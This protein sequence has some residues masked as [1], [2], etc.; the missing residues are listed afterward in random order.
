MSRKIRKSSW[1]PFQRGDISEKQIEKVAQEIS[2]RFDLPIDA[3]TAMARYSL[4]G[5]VWINNKYQV[6]L[7]RYS[8]DGVDSTALHLSIKRIDKEPIR[9]WRDLQRIKNELCGPEVELVELYPKESR[10]VDGSNQFHLWGFDS[11]D[12]QF[13]FGFDEGRQVSNIPLDG[14]NQRFNE[15]YEED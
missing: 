15:D 5:E 11:E 3:A 12:M 1:T 2:T 13:P 7:R 10:M 8:I 9:D 14:G 4:Q 6:V